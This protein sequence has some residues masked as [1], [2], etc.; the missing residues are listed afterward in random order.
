MASAGREGDE[1]TRRQMRLGQPN[2][3]L[4][5]DRRGIDPFTDRFEVT[6]LLR[7][8]WLPHANLD[9]VTQGIE[10]DDENPAI[11]ERAR[12]AAIDAALAFWDDEFSKEASDDNG[13]VI[14]PGSVYHTQHPDHYTVSDVGRLWIFPDDDTWVDAD[15]LTSGNS[16]YERE[17][18][19]AALYSPW[20]D[21][22]NRT[23]V[24]R[25]ATL[26]GAIGESWDWVPRRRQFLDLIGRV[27]ATGDR[28]PILYLTFTDTDPQ[29]ALN[30]R[31]N[32]VPYK[33]APHID[34][35]SAAITLTEPNLFTA[36][37]LKGDP[38]ADDGAMLR[39][40]MEGRFMV[41]ITCTLLGDRRMS[42]SRSG[43]SAALSRQRHRI[44]DLG[45]ER[46]RIRQRRGQNSFL[47]VQPV[48]EDPEYEDRD[49][50]PAL[51]RL[52]MGEARLMAQSPVAGSFEIPFIDQT[53][54]L[55]DSF[56]GAAGLGIEFATYPEV[57]SV[58][59]VN[60]QEA[61]MRTIVHLTD[62]RDSPEVGGE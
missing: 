53:Y 42:T 15:Y 37:S 61:D 36:E 30:R 14:G 58:E 50:T 20:Q 47:N 13:K 2:F 16:R 49:D 44:V 33:S 54:K 45:Y 3:F 27:D 46:F 26:G 12:K 41:A 1:D 25:H 51:E 11:A 7:P 17:H 57:I 35:D 55:G 48:D 6:L 60:S 24:L 38:D 29:A 23:N 19:P 32:W 59:F 5:F 52:A 9:N 22:Q 56:S 43:G 28:A 39:A 31:N 4:P 62:L 18:W 21:D 40:Y 34:P 10:E 8:G